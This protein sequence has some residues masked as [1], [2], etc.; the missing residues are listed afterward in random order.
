VTGRGSETGCSGSLL[1]L[2]GDLKRL[3]AHDLTTDG[4]RALLP[5]LLPEGLAILNRLLRFPERKAIPLPVERS[6]PQYPP[7]KPDCCFAWGRTVSWVN[8]TASS[9]RSGEPCSVVSRANIV[10]SSPRPLSGGSLGKGKIRLQKRAP[11]RP[12]PRV[13]L[14]EVLLQSPAPP[15]TKGLPHSSDGCS[16]SPVRDELMEVNVHDVQD[17]PE[18]MPHRRRWSAS[19]WIRLLL[20]LLGAAGLVTAAFVDW[21]R[22]IGPQGVTLHMRMLWNPNEPTTITGGGIASVRQGLGHRGGEPA[23][24]PAQT[25]LAHRFEVHAPI[26][27]LSIHRCSSHH[28]HLRIRPRSHGGAA[29]GAFPTF[30]VPVRGRTWAAAALEA[31]GDLGPGL[32]TRTFVA[33]LALLPTNS[34][35][36]GHGGRPS[37]RGAARWKRTRGRR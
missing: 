36:R 34:D 2:G 14:P 12:E 29:R 5:H 26:L 21:I 35:T 11:R 30:P 13:L 17:R 37:L 32:P 4:S 23:L 15:T 7:W 18:G 19:R 6:R 20:T 28:A 8:R 1:A 24:Q 22:S 33:G 3:D 31:I 9:A 16:S 27:P 10:S 25:D